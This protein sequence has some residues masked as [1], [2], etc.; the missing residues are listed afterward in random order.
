[1]SYGGI[2]CPNSSDSSRSTSAED[3]IRVASKVLAAAVTSSNARRQQHQKRRIEPTPHVLP[4]TFV[5]VRASQNRSKGIL[6]TQQV[7][8]SS[9]IARNRSPHSSFKKI[10]SKKQ[11]KKLKLQ[12]S[13]QRANLEPDRT[14]TTANLIPV[15]E[16]LTRVLYELSDVRSRE[17]SRR[18]VLAGLRR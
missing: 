15:D 2:L 17:R 12:S 8:F 16:N 6:K 18:F 13:L 11:N 1:M 3:P 5:A 10:K 9:G 4:S 7:P 14:L